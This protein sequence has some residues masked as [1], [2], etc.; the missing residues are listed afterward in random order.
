MTPA[1]LG[2]LSKRDFRLPKRPL[3]QHSTSRSLRSRMAVRTQM[4]RAVD[5]RLSM[6]RRHSAR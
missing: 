2:R 4:Q 3:T 6:S 1:T 5:S